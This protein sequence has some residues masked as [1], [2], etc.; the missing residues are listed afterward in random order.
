MMAEFIHDVALSDPALNTVL[1]TII[2]GLVLY[3]AAFL[4][5]LTSIERKFKNLS[6]VFDSGLVRQLLGYEGTSAQTLMTETVDLFRASGIRCIM[7]DKSAHEIQ[8][9]LSMFQVKLAT[10]T[11][12]RSLRP[13][14]MARHF[15]TCRYSP[16]DVQEMSALLES[17]IRDASIQIVPAPEHRKELT[18]REPALAKRLADPCT[19]DLY[20]PRVLHDVDCVAGVLTSRRGHRTNNI[21][22]ARYVFATASPLV[23]RNVK[24]W[25]KE[26]ERETGVSPVVNV[27]L[28]ANL[29]WLKNPTASVDLQLHELVALCAAAMRPSE[30]TWE[31]FLSHLDKLHTSQRLSEH[32][33]GAIIASAVAD[34]SLRDAE[35]A[36][37]DGDDFDS[38][39]LD[40]AIERVS[41]DYRAEAD[42]RV[43][44]VSEQYEQKVAC[45]GVAADERLRAARSAADT[46]SQELRRRDRESERRAKAIARWIVGIPYWLLSSTVVAGSV[47]LA[48]TYSVTGGWIDV[49]IGGAVFLV[50]SLELIGVLHHLRAAR[51]SVRDWLKRRLANWLKGN[52]STPPGTD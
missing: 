3:Y 33:I 50:M 35:L 30:Q 7:F 51:S 31:R 10:H 49:V 24:R 17:R 27:R 4:A 21:E 37:E 2:Q 26:D 46:N 38:G 48:L 8:R 25:W 16:S 36:H 13:T 42:A 39:T 45:D 43:R 15:L 5:D 40:E 18:H 1:R 44:T 11:G 14:P 29:A 22:D 34:Q 23:V 28:L 9:I 6:V 20:E 32:E 19:R 52:R 47:A 41:S 12:R